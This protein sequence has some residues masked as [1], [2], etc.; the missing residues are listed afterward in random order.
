M[1]TLLESSAS[2]R[3]PSTE[4]VHSLRSVRSR[5]WT[6]EVQKNWTLPVPISESLEQRVARY[7]EYFS[8]TSAQLEHVYRNILS[9]M[10]DGCVAH[11]NPG[12]ARR[13]SS[14]KMLDTCITKLPEGRE[15]GIGYALEFSGT[16]VRALR[17]RME[18]NNK[19]TTIEHRL[20]IRDEKTQHPKGLLDKQCGAMAL[21]NYLGGAVG[22]LIRK[23]GAPKTEVSCGFVLAF[24]CTVNSVNSATLLEWTKGFETGRAT[25]D[26]VEGLDVATLLDMAFWRAEINAKTRAV[27]NDASGTLLACAY[28]RSSRLPP[29]TVAFLIGVGL[30]GAYVEPHAAS[31]GYKGCVINTELGGFDKDL[32]V[33]DVDLEVDYA[34][35]G[36]RGKQVFEKMIGGGYLGEVCRRLVVKVWQNEA[37]PLSWAR[38]SLP[39]AAAAL[40]VSDNSDTLTMVDKLLQGLWDWQTTHETRRTIQKLFALVFDRSAALAAASIAALA[41]KSG[42][43]QPAMGGVTVAVDG[44]LHTSHPWY[45]DIVRTYLKQILGEE[46]AHYVHLFVAMNGAAK[47]AALLAHL[48][49]VQ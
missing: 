44:A 10:E 45:S 20:N 12:A 39:T 46:T 35:E 26:P 11:A 25:E 13:Q 31:Y 49:S 47:G 29:C 2:M 32:P 40:C 37:P 43:L 33:T 36:G 18:G 5:A 7:S 27:V 24:P 4:S 41:K 22:E 3:R 9:E 23:S 17:A 28:E 6:D 42:R 14:L 15:K 30:N 34:D 8:I 19:I 48:E 38:Q 1:T 16:T 21:F